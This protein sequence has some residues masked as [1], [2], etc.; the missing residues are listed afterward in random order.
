MSSPRGSRR[1]VPLVGCALLAVALV[2]CTSVTDG[3]PVGPGSLSPSPVGSAPTPVPGST[4]SSDTTPP[5]VG[6]CSASYAAP[7]PNR[8]RVALAFRFSA[9]LSTVRGTEHISFT[10]DKPITEL[11][12]RLTANTVPT[13]A[14]GNKIVV[15][16]AT[17]DHG[18]TKATYTPAGADPSTQGGLLHIPFAQQIAAGT[19]VSADIAFTITIGAESFDRFG[20]TGNAAQRYSWIGSG[21]PLLAWER[22]FGWHSEDL[23]QFTAESATSEAMDTALAVTAPT[24][25]TV[26]MSGDPS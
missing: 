3:T 6:N 21:Q 11:I 24:N 19:T 15:E 2:G 13:V 17:A 8:P 12:F 10:P 4:A 26:I 1:R 22:G 16:S 7:D 20:R 25:D 5:P 14:E 23:I 9:D 18:A